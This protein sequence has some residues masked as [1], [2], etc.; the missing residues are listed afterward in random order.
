MQDNN[1]SEEKASW[2]Q[3]LIAR[4]GKKRL[5]I[6]A[7]AV[8]AGLWIANVVV[9]WIAG[10]DQPNEPVAVRH[11]TPA[12]APKD[13]MTVKD[14]VASTPPD[15]HRVTA[16]SPKDV[17][18]AKDVSAGTLPAPAQPKAGHGRTAAAPAESQEAV[19]FIKGVAFVDALIGPMDYE[20]NQRF[21]G[22]RPNDIINVTDNVNNFQ[23]GALEVTRRTIVVLT[24]R[25]SRTGSTAA[26][27]K[28]LENAMNW[29]MMR[30]TQYWFPSPE[31][32]YG[33]ALKAMTKYRDRI[34]KGGAPFY[35]RSDNLIP[36]LIAYEDLL[37]SSDENLVKHY[38]ANGDPVSFFKSDDYIFYAKGVA[39]AMHPIL[40]A[41]AVDFAQTLEARRG[42]DVIHHAIESLE[43]AMEVSPIVI[44]NSN[45]SG[46]LANHRAN[47]AA[48][49]SHARFYLGVLIKTL[50]T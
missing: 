22:W 10:S 36:L 11:V 50:S 19:Q 24:E 29:L 30:P 38:E 26:F 18:S 44:T 13:E 35:T 9:G 16:E 46:I 4:F 23:L 7:V 3:R 20:L 15:V 8:L 37:G 1:H 45:L 43:Y 12:P 32:M 40:S 14:P 5:I 31:A 49:I 39:S 2:M 28:D 41:V 34:I 48:P 25:I 17:Y 27:D 42:V 6:G 21:W 47:M 33:D